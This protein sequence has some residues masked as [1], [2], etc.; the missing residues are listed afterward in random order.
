MKY[1]HLLL[2]A[3][4]LFLSFMA[5]KIGVSALYGGSSESGYPWV[6]YLIADMNDGN[7]GQC[8]A[9]FIAPNAI[10]TA[11]HC[12]EGFSPDDIY[13]GTGRYTGDFRSAAIKASMIYVEPNY[14]KPLNTTEAG[15]NDVAVVLLKESASISSYATLD[16]PV[17]G[18][19]YYVVGYGENEDNDQV[20][21]RGISICVK[22]LND[23][24]LEIKPGQQHF[25]VGDSGSGVYEKGTN[26]LIGVVST[27]NS[28]LGGC[29]TALN[30][31]AT[32]IDSN[33]D[34]IKKHASPS[35][36]IITD[37]Q[38]QNEKT[39]EITISKTDQDSQGDD[40]VSALICVIILSICCM[41]VVGI[42]IFIFLFFYIL[43]KAL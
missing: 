17:I 4:F 32:R 42:F 5:V 20:D 1:K 16:T 28:P 13:V 12:V 10:V 25:C 15:R 31:Y 37:P 19:D 21:R 9:N 8:G 2:T 33:L 40:L 24:H 26:K 29:D 3:V 30:F 14:T 22:A 35:S 43:K 11:A 6:G 27:F 23:Y 38:S 34:F 36:S 41:S 39:E 7:L 18:C